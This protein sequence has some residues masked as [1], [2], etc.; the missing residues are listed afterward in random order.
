MNFSHHVLATPLFGRYWFKE[1]DNVTDID[2]ARCNQMK[3]LTS[4][5]SEDPVPAKSSKFEYVSIFPFDSILNT[6]ILI[7]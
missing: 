5:R 4:E 6:S 3:E 2:D 7:T 1:P